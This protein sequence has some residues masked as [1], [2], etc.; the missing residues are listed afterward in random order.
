MQYARRWSIF[1]NMVTFSLD[2]AKPDR[3]KNQSRS[4]LASDTKH[5]YACS[6]EKISKIDALK[7]SLRK[8]GPLLLRSS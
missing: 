2:N 7:M 5:T 8:F 1:A 4:Y 3:G 6:P